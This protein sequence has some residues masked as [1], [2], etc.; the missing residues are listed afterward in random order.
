M[1]QVLEGLRVT[2]V[3]SMTCRELSIAR[4]QCHG[5]ISGIF[6]SGGLR[7]KLA[8]GTNSIVSG[9]I[10]TNWKIP[11]PL[12]QRGGGIVQRGTDAG[13]GHLKFLAVLADLLLGFKDIALQPRDFFNSKSK[14]TGAAFRNIACTMLPGSQL[15]Q[16]RC[17]IPI[18]LGVGPQPSPNM[19][20]E[21]SDEGRK[22][23][24]TGTEGGPNLDGDKPGNNIPRTNGRKGK[25]PEGGRR[26]GNGGHGPKHED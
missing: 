10:Q 25:M 16:Y 21:Q 20:G 14:D 23:G 5:T 26:G 15:Q 22:A 9:I 8:A 18:G 19:G 1:Q 2:V 7:V 3:N 11:G 24:T 17:V 4:W 12:W 6:R 13:V